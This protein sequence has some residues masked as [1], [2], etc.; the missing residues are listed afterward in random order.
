VFEEPIPY[1]RLLRE[2]RQTAVS[3]YVTIS[4]SEG[5]LPI[6]SFSVG[7]PCLIGPGSHLF[8][9]HDL[10]REMLVVEQPYNPGLI[11]DMAMAAAERSAELLAAYRQYNDEVEDRA[12][13]GLAHFLA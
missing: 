13:D 7:V 1:E 5:L 6:E 4:E 11:A 12:R 8:R 2:M 10:L 3:L 9:D